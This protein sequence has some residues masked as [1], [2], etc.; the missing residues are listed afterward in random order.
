M[1]MKAESREP[2]I[3]L[4]ISVTERPDSADF[5]RHC[6]GM[7]EMI[8]VLRGQGSYMVEGTEYPLQPNTVMLLLPYEYHYVRLEEDAPYE[9]CVINFSPD[10]PYDAVKTL[11]RFE[12][13]RTAGRY[14]AVEHLPGNIQ[15]IFASLDIL[16]TFC[17]EEGHQLNGA[18]RALLRSMLTQLLILLGATGAEDP[19]VAEETPLSRVL[20]YLNENL[21]ENISL[22]DLSRRFFV[23][24]YHLC[25]AFRQYTGTTF[26]SYLTTKRIV[27]A[28]R[29]LEEGMPATQVAYRVGFGDYSSF[30]RAYRKQT[31]HAP[32]GE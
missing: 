29:L 1:N 12:G 26:L 14:F 16:R 32:R 18:G 20:V 4:R 31:G 22:D 19:D 25:R 13:N 15:Q 11:N 28:G 27:L 6:H 30:Y 23:S 3:K 2:L 21:G 5:E 24:K 8:Y 10:A 9:R 17:K 7:Y